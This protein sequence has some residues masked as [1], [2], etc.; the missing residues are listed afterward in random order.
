M[1]HVDKCSEAQTYGAT[2]Q[3]VWDYR[4]DMERG[5]NG[6]PFEPAGADIEGKPGSVCQA[7]PSVDAGKEYYLNCIKGF[8]IPLHENEC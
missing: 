8:Y 2:G 4:G 5:E 3:P 6:T 1:S 7:M